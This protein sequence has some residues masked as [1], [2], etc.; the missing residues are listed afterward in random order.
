VKTPRAIAE[1]VLIASLSLWLGA[2]VMS[3]ATAAI[4]FPTMKGLNPSLPGITL[5]Q[6]EH[7]LFAAGRVAN[8]VFELAAIFEVACAVVAVSTF[9]GLLSRRVGPMTRTAA[10]ARVL[11]LAAACGVLAYNV[12][13]LAPR[14]RQNLDAYWSA[15]QSG[16]AAAAHTSRSAF[17]A[18]HPVASRT[19]GIMAGCVF[20]ALVTAGLTL[21]RA[22]GKD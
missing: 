18:D 3:G 12:G 2:L 20:A 11:T 9:V 22:P 1:S 19:L 16:D 4:I 5:D 6:T 7:W 17:D 13:V 14:M 15:A 10:I 21:G 8:R